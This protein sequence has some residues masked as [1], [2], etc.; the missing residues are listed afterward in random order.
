MHGKYKIKMFNSIVKLLNWEISDLMERLNVAISVTSR[1]L[2]GRYS[3][4]CE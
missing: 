2:A 3:S 4:E 1:R